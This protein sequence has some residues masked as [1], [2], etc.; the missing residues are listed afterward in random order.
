MRYSKTRSSDQTFDINLAPFLDIIVSVV[1]LLL[2]SVVFVEI[3][4]IETP[5]PQVVQQAIEKEQK[6]PN[7]EVTLNLRVAKN[8]GFIFEVTQKGATNSMTVPLLKE[9]G[10]DWDG[11]RNKTIEIKGRFPQVFKLGLAPQ[12]DVQFSDLV[13]AMDTV[14]RLPQQQ[15]DRKVAFTDTG[16]G[17]KVETD[18]LFPNVMFSNVVG[19]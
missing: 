5:V 6:D 1:P 8:K 10:Y 12:G 9:G 16:T 18:L 17:Q 11:L 15:M 13:K 7:P 3:K 2:L 14:R 19:D 4:M